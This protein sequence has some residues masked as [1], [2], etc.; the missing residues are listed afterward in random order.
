MEPLV[1]SVISAGLETIEIT[2]NTEGASDL[3]KEAV[4][5]AK[6]KLMVG[7]G[8][9]LDIKSLKSA[10]E[11]G[12]TFVVTPVLVDDVTLYCVKN[13][14]PIF[15]GALTPS[16]VRR[17]WDSGATMVKVFPAKFFGPDYFKE[18]KGPFDDMKL[19][20]CAGVTPE[21]LK[22]YFAAGAN[23]VTFGASVFRRDWLEE[24]DFESIKERIK[25]YIGAYKKMGS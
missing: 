13:K 4:L 5:L 1:K 22:D 24:K 25:A 23:A 8:T 12:A 7:A 20:A 18:I 2:M 15:P 14:I 9:V 16:E 6:K 11:S 19:L 3:I 10:L 17:A 21:N